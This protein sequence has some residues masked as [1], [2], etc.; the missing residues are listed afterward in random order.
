MASRSP[1]TPNNF[2]LRMHG[3]AFHP[4]MRITRSTRGTP[5][6]KRRL[7]NGQSSV[8]Y[9]QGQAWLP[10]LRRPASGRCHEQDGGK[11]GLLRGEAVTWSLCT[12]LAAVSLWSAPAASAAPLRHC[13]APSPN[14]GLGPRDDQYVPFGDVTARGT[15]CSAALSAIRSGHLN[16]KFHTP[17]FTCKV[18]KQYYIGIPGQGGT[19]SGQVIHCAAPGRAFQWSWAT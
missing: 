11:V 8:G 17:G 3:I 1:P 10:R 19:P 15:S 9:G 16:P 7:S 2:F 6:M 18:V 13:S 5:G 12:V 4:M 14:A